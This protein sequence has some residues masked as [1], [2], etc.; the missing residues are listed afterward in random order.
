MKNIN[1]HL[2]HETKFGSRDIVIDVRTPEEYHLEH[3]DGAIN[4]P[5]DQFDDFVA[6]L[7]SYENI[8]IYCNTGN[9]STLFAQKA[10]SQGIETII[11][12]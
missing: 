1:T 9:S 4:M 6:K 5:V 8:Y 10:Q 3:I 7:P 12:L 2:L 11:V